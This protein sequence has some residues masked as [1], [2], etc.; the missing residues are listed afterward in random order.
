[1]LALLTVQIRSA[2]WPLVV[3]FNL[4]GAADIIVDY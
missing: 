1:M 4:A 2:Y 3:A